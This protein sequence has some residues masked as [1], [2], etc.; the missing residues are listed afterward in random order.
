MRP[1]KDKCFGLESKHFVN[2][3][4][5]SFKFGHCNFLLR[6]LDGT[7]W[8]P[9]S[10]DLRCVPS[11]VLSF[12]WQF[13]FIWLKPRLLDARMPKSPSLVCAQALIQSFDPIFHAMQI[14]RVINEFNV[15]QINRVN[16]L[17]T[18]KQKKRAV[19]VE[20]KILFEVGSLVHIVN[21][22]SQGPAVWPLL[23][24]SKK[25]KQWEVV[26]GESLPLSCLYPPSPSPSPP[27]GSWHGNVWPKKFRNFSNIW[28]AGTFL[29]VK[30]AA[31]FV[32]QN[33]NTSR[34]ILM[35]HSIKYLHVSR[36]YEF[37]KFRKFPELFGPYLMPYDRHCC[38]RRCVTVHWQ[39]PP[40]LH[41]W[42]F[43]YM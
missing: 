7:D 25:S 3:Q 13:A 27:V 15:N 12:E 1:L 36:N 39:C 37:L 16:P 34:H 24:L 11:M 6:S 43:A 29:L 42:N 14:Q 4:H 35:R 20:N 33:L 8:S 28:L 41:C 32:L 10:M 30:M 17:R 5:L 23:L 26:E 2:Q 22:K 21:R 38:Q 31:I 9:H 18:C 40:G 19:N